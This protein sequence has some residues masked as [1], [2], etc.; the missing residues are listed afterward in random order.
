L[1]QLYLQ[2]YRREAK[3]AT[4]LD[5]KPLPELAQQAVQWQYALMQV[6]ASISPPQFAYEIR[7]DAARARYA[8]SVDGTRILEDVNLMIVYFIAHMPTFYGNLPTITWWTAPMSLRATEAQMNARL[9]TFRAISASIQENP[10]WHEH[11]MKFSAIITREQLRE[12]QAVF[13]QLDRI[14]QSQSEM[15]DQLY[16]SWRRR[17]DAQDRAFD[18]YDRSLR[19]VQTYSDPLASRQVELPHGYRHAWSNGSDYILSDD[20]AFNPGASRGGTWTEIHP[21]R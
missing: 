12:Q 5:V 17:G 11:L 3:D 4:I 13:K 7:A 10:V 21:D 18:N 19:G 20:P 1:R 6:F 9:E 15:S 8:Y 2:N 14:R 16:E